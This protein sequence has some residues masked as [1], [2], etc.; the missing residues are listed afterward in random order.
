MA[1]YFASNMVGNYTII[2]LAMHMPSI[3]D[4][5]SDSVEQP[6]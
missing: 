5:L 1:L 2:S 6:F 3:I 4:L